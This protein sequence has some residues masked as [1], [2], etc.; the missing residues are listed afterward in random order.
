MQL[1]DCSTAD[2]WQYLAADELLLAGAEEGRIGETLR[3]GEIET[4]A[5]V[6][7]VSQRWREAV[8]LEHCRA[9]G[10]P[11][12]RRCSGG[13]AVLI[14]RGCLNYSLILDVSRDESLRGI[15]G[16]YGWI[17][18][19]IAEA[20]SACGPRVVHAGLSDLA[21]DGRK[22]GGSAQKR[23]RR[24]ILHHGTLLHGAFD[25]SPMDD[26]LPFPTRVPDY[27][28]ARRHADFVSTLPL[29]ADQLR[30]AVC[31]AFAVPAGAEPRDLDAAVAD[32]VASKYGTDEW[33]FRR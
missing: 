27:R 24:Y 6:M 4:P 30:A 32:L 15:H 2:P 26:L 11:V 12:L 5:V 28:G 33:T 22:V 18:P 13:G 9:A 8:H 20:L 31:H 10:V 7:G 3:F 14:G 16:S 1:I 21:W 17:V 29:T 19:R 23:R 25:A